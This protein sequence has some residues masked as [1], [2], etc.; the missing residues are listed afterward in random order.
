M[1]Y[2]AGCGITREDAEWLVAC[3]Y[4]DAHPGSVDAAGVIQNAL[5]RELRLVALNHPQRMAILGV[6]DECPVGLA[7]LRGQLARDERLG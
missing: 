2:L 1:L 3:L 5:T 4:A 6:M 7:E